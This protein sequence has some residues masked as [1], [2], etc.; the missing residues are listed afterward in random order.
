MEGATK[1]IFERD[2]KN[3][4]TILPQALSIN[5]YENIQIQP[6]ITKLGFK[7]QNKKNGP[8][9]KNLDSSKSLF[10]KSEKKFQKNWKFHTFKTLV[11]SPFA[12]DEIFYNHLMRTYHQLKLAKVLVKFSSFFEINENKFIKLNYCN[13]LIFKKNY[14]FS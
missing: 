9:K 1:G 8:L 5:S 2:P 14:K 7:L 11:F 4:S 6:K 10:F 13:L 3:N 12:T